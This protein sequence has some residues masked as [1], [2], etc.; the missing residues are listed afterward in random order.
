[1]NTYQRIFGT[2]P[3]GLIISTLLL[4]LAFFAAP[5]T[6]MP[7]IIQHNEIRIWGAGILTFLTIVVVLWSVKSLPPVD[8]GKRL[9][10]TGAFAWFRH[11][12]YAAFLSF[13]NFG[14][15]LF[16]NN[17]IYLLWAVAQHPVWHWNMRAEENLVREV[18]GKEY[19]AYTQRTSR[20]LPTRTLLRYIQR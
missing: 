19:E 11:P 16:L 12:L 1:M 14:L 9:V 2:G 15:A 7:A 8:R 18:F 20:F 4:L 10:T 3:R 17:R 5:Y 6:D 13:F